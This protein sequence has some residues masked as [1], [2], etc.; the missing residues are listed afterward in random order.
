LHC[1]Q[2][3][4][5]QLLFFLGGQPRVASSE[6]HDA[7][8]KHGAAAVAA[9]GCT[10]LQV[11]SCTQLSAL[12]AFVCRPQQLLL[13]LLLFLVVSHLLHHVSC[14]VQRA[15]RSSGCCS[16][17]PHSAAGTLLYASV[18]TVRI[19]VQA[20]TAAA[21]AVLGGEHFVA[22]REL[23]DAASKP[24]KWLLQLWAVPQVSA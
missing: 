3:P 4:Q 1:L 20:A 19:C 23:H 24:E 17:W 12:Y 16:C 5:Q 9:A 7:V 21:A 11:R 22:A 14:M 6:L 8:S 10:A 18:C 15:N 13:L 2:R